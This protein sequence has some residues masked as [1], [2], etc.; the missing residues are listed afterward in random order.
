MEGIEQ[1]ESGIVGRGNGFAVTVK[2]L[3]S[4]NRIGMEGGSR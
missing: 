1:R 4:H 3:E 2:V